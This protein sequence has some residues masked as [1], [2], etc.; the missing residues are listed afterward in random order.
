[1]P[2]AVRARA[3]DLDYPQRTESCVTTEL[4]KSSLI[5]NFAPMH[6]VSTSFRALTAAVSFLWRSLRYCL[7][8]IRCEAE[9]TVNLCI[10]PLMPDRHDRRSRIRRLGTARIISLFRICAAT[11]EYAGPTSV[12]RGFCGI[13]ARGVLRRAHRSRPRAS[14]VD[15]HILRRP[16]CGGR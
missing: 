13:S 1:M 15:V 4:A 10:S 9:C 16:V 11:M 3:M 6:P 12:S 5:D 8:E 7:Q 2:Q 14:P